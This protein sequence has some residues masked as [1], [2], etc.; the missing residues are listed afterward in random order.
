LRAAAIEGWI[1]FRSLELDP[2]F[3]RLRDDAA[4]KEISESMMTRVAS[5]RRSMPAILKG[6]KKGPLK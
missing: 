6:E 5:L 4:F 1:D 2:R 3:D